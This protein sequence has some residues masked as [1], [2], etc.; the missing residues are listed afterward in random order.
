MAVPCYIVA[1][2]DPWIIEGDEKT[3]MQ[4][5]REQYL[6]TAVAPASDPDGAINTLYDMAALVMAGFDQR[7]W[8]WI[9]VS[10]PIRIDSGGVQYLGVTIR[11]GH[12]VDNTMLPVIPPG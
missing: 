2:G 12:S 8:W 9:G 10:G 5:H 6:I 3:P 4:H 1:P 7:G 11:A